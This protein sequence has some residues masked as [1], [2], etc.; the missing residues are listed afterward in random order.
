MGDTDGPAAGRF[1]LSLV[2]F[3]R[4]SSDTT[5]VKRGKEPGDPNAP[6]PTLLKAVEMPV[7]LTSGLTYD[8]LVVTA[9]TNSVHS[10][11]YSPHRRRQNRSHL[12]N[13]H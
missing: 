9:Q 12:R 7:A 10:Y 8:S 2:Y 5:R 3:H 4:I 11:C 13:L 1:T 6:I